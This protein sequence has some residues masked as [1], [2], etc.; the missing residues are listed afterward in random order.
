MA[1]YRDPQ[2]DSP[3]VHSPLPDASKYIRLLRARSTHDADTLAFDLN[4]HSLH[5]LPPYIAI[6]YVWGP[7]SER[8]T[9]T[10]NDH[11][12]TVA[13]N[14][15]EALR[16]TC[17]DDVD[18]YM[19][20]DSICINQEDLEEKSLQVEMMADIYRAA[21]LVYAC[22]G[23][24]EPDIELLL[25]ACFP[26][27]EA[28][29][30]SFSVRAPEQYCE[31]PPHKTGNEI[32]TEWLMSRD[33]EDLITM[34]E[35]FAR[36][37]H[38]SYWRR[39][40]IVQEICMGDNIQIRCGSHAFDIVFLMQFEAAFEELLELPLPLDCCY[41]IEASWAHYEEGAMSNAFTTSAETKR[42]F[43]SLLNEMKH[44][45]CQDARDRVYALNAMINWGTGQPR[46]KPDYR[47]STFDLLV[48]AIEH[49]RVDEHHPDAT[50]AHVESLGEMV[51]YGVLTALNITSSHPQVSS[52]VQLRCSLQSA[53]MQNPVDEGPILRKEYSYAFARIE[54]DQCGRLAVAYH[55]VR[56]HHSEEATDMLRMLENAQSD[57]SSFHELFKD[58]L[59]QPLFAKQ[60][61]AGIACNG[62]RPED[63]LYPW[64]AWQAAAE[65]VAQV[66]IVL[67]H[68][69]ATETCEI[70]G[71]A[72]IFAHYEPDDELPTFSEIAEAKEALQQLP[73][74]PMPSGPIFE[75]TLTAEDMVILAAQD[76]LTGKEAW[77][78]GI[79]PRKARHVGRKLDIEARF[80][81]LATAVTLSSTCGAR[82]LTNCTEFQAYNAMH[83][84]CAFGSSTRTPARLEEK[85][86]WL[87]NRTQ[88]GFVAMEEALPIRSF[89]GPFYYD[90]NESHTRC[91]VHGPIGSPT[92]FTDRST[93]VFS[94]K[95]PMS[96][97][98]RHVE[99]ICH[100]LRR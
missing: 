39:M 65:R 35:V 56:D 76:F 59:P 2:G 95:E 57:S 98:I 12:F 80:R 31:Q 48:Q 8:H 6:S 24:A 27:A 83:V 49:I 99:C 41:C 36:L 87:R 30:Y 25:E 68:C 16:Q 9:V 91:P 51:R 89:A 54:S 64:T 46:L 45:E 23:P 28:R 3:Y 47:K 17:Q 69:T 73:K 78:G 50:F 66:Y 85:A 37:A 1:E 92:S 86:A 22:I 79:E 77:I 55:A 38:R 5:N 43:G 97:P 40:W 42:P 11:P 15:R 84:A 62:A 71:Q 75:L 33:E 90:P 88:T 96:T 94:V 10:I 20:M 19:W 7:S 74:C 61:I 18:W 72:L 44:L 60:G 53:T 13:T 81:R 67:R 29:S 32:A 70:I 34:C 63:F 100:I 26:L 4:E 58:R 93:S 82:M 21:S 52:G 14:A